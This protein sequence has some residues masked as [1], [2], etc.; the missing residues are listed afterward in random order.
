MMEAY[1]DPSFG[2]PG[3][4]ASDIT[5]VAAHSWN[6]GEAAFNK[7]LNIGQERP[8]IAVGDETR[9]TTPNGDLSYVVERIDLY[10]KGTLAQASFWDVM[11]GRLLVLITCFYTAEG[12]STDNMVVIARLR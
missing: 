12:I 1:W 11:D 9:V 2:Q 10:R 3:T 6:K 8:A 7:L 5:V 4:D